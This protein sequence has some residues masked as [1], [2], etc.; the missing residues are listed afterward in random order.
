MNTL[1]SLRGMV[2][3]PH[4][5]ASQTGLSVLQD[6]GTAIDATI[7]VAAVLSVVYP[8]ML[9]IG[10]D[11]FW[12]VG[13]A[14]SQ[15]P[16]AIQACGRAGERVSQR[17]FEGHAAIPAH[18]PLAVNTVAGAVSGWHAAQA[19]S[20][21]WGSTLPTSRLLRDAVEYAVRGVPASQN[22][23][24]VP[25]GVQ[26]A[27]LREPTFQR[28]FAPDH[29]WPAPGSLMRQP[30]LG[31]T[32]QRLAHDG[33]DTFY[34]GDVARDMAADLADIRS[35]LTLDDLGRHRAV[36]CE[37]LQV[38]TSRGR[39]YNVPPPTQGATALMILGT[40]DQ[41]AWDAAHLDSFEHAHALIEA[42]KRAYQ[43][44][45]SITDPTYMTTD[46]RATLTP[47]A[48]QSEAR[49]IDLTKSAACT[50]PSGPGDTAWM[51]VVDQ[52]GRAC[53]HIQSV[54]HPF[55]SHMVLPRTGI[56]WQN[57]GSSF[58]LDDNAQNAL[59]PGRL[60]FHTLNPAMAHLADGRLVTYGTMGAHA[61]PQISSSVLFRHAWLQ[62]PL[63]AAVSAPRWV[64]DGDSVVAE[65]RVAP[66]LVGQLRA[67][68]HRV[69]I[70]SAY[71]TFLGH[72][73]AIARR[74][75]GTLE[76]AADPRSDGAVA[77]Y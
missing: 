63:Q 34:R 74:P 48:L 24:E 8:H 68:G 66:E 33:L 57:R 39:F 16:V 31:R 6:G 3:S 65:S 26:Q 53:S 30:A 67:A 76:G 54:F 25:P 61:Q 55:G 17:L 44:R 59:A 62:Q 56:V 46:I 73:H 75:D 37:P 13:D 43:A 21:Q 5:L 42:S 70:T 12:L 32:L 29:Q 69:R 50:A 64:V 20:R 47:S 40:L 35:P 19:I 7:A 51:G 22:M 45:E 71:D 1:Y 28:V 9:S 14:S 49:K 58:S 38:E 11:A 2:T 10:G 4:H 41:F 36:L 77:A 18:G 72:A 27:L 60:P 15:P 23:A 52:D